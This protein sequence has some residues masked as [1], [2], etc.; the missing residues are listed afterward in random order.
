MRIAVPYY[1]LAILIGLA[2]LS[3]LALP[4][5]PPATPL[6]IAGLQNTFRV[7]DQIY[8]GSQ[9]D[10]DQAFAAL[11]KLGIKTV[12][13]VDGSK[14]DVER[15][16]KFGLEY[17]HLPFGYDG[18]PSN[19]V[20]DLAKVTTVKPGPFYVHCHH[21]MHRGPAAVAV[22]CESVEGWSSD[23]ALAWL[24][25]AGTSPDYPG[26]FRAARS[27]HKPSQSAL[28]AATHFPE[29]AST[30][31]LVDTMVAIDEHFAKL[32]K[33]KQAG[34]GSLPGD[35]DFSARHEAT[36]LWEQ[37]HELSRTGVG[38]ARPPEFQQKLT[39]AERAAD[40]LRDLLRAQP[41][42]P[43]ALD[44]ALASTAQSCTACHRVFRNP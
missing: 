29:T 15:A 26:L 5:P 20:A 13:T 24:Q 19:R 36:L 2:L 42:E 17:V 3:P 11:A 18:V 16:H 4:A 41:I 28:A 25:E 40:E 21:G 38:A 10:T 9:P 33:A 12:I 34:W 43:P 23:Q 8:S 39:G 32:Q 27:F 37:L 1:A 44:K 14:P 35:P 31:S 7:T 22:I 30:S 6:P